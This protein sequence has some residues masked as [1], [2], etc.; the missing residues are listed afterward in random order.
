[1]DYGN[2]FFNL[3]VLSKYMIFQSTWQ[4]P[5]YISPEIYRAG[6]YLESIVAIISFTFWLFMVAK[7]IQKRTKISA[8]LATS[9][10]GFLV[11]LFSTLIEKLLV[12]NE[13]Y[14]YPQIV[15]DVKIGLFGAFGALAFLYFYAWFV[16]NAFL[17]DIKTWAKK[18]LQIIQIL[19]L[20]LFLYG[21]VLYWIPLSPENLDILFLPISG[22]SML[23]LIPLLIVSIISFYQIL[24]KVSAPKTAEERLNLVSIRSLSIN[25]FILLLFVILFGADVALPN[26]GMSILYFIAWSLI[27]VSFIFGYVGYFHPK[28]L[29]RIFQSKYEK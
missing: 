13:V 8:L 25:A 15:Y 17:V 9:Y 6:M 23:L 28:W 11:L 3:F 10:L 21:I 4:L 18:T 24:N 14:T 5:E 29:V 2:H 12:I 26:M 20:G 27:G 16:Y 1:M 22:L 19:S 7:Y